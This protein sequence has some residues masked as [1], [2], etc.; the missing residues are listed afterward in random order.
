M[1]DTQALSRK[2]ILRRERVDNIFEFLKELHKLTEAGYVRLSASDLARKHNITLITPLLK[3]IISLGLVRRNGNKANRHYHWCNNNRLGPTFTMAENLEIYIQSQKQSKDVTHKKS[4]IP[5]QNTSR[6]KVVPKGD[7]PPMGKIAQAIWEMYKE[8]VSISLKRY[9]EKFKMDESVFD[10]LIQLGYLKFSKIFHNKYDWCGPEPENELFDIIMETVNQDTI[11]ENVQ[12]FLKKLDNILLSSDGKFA[13]SNLMKECNVNPVT[14]TILIHY[15]YITAEPDP[16]H[17]QRK[18][19]RKIGNWTPNS[20]LVAIFRKQMK[21][22]WN[23]DRSQYRKKNDSKNTNDKT[24]I[25]NDTKIEVV[26]DLGEKLKKERDGMKAKIIELQ[27]QITEY[28]AKIEAI[29][30]TLNLLKNN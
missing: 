15:N 19:Y 24:D 13:M 20:S 17:G 22:Y 6:I 8:N 28:T 29:D 21:E 3:G 5:I 11:A 12:V 7:K 27:G 4:L 1:N 30:W 18:I 26:G 23:A 25:K 2:E 16:T 14:S 10:P 9:S